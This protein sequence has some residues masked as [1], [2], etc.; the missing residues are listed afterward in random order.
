MLRKA[1]EDKKLEER[2][3]EELRKALEG[4]KLRERSKDKRLEEAKSKRLEAKKKLGKGLK[5]E[6][7]KKIP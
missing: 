4:E 6:R 2:L 5:G 1:L 7:P 3:L